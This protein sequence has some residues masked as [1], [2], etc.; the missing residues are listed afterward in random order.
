[1]T[2]EVPSRADE[3]LAREMFVSMDR[4]GWIKADAPPREI[5]ALLASV[6]ARLC[7]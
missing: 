6:I 5:V 4:N 3:T 1:M 2:R 7:K